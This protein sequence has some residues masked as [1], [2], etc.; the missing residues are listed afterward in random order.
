MQKLESEKK[1]WKKTGLFHYAKVGSANRKREKLLQRTI[2]P[3]NKTNA[4]ILLIH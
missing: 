2:I 3:A 4:Q 1:G